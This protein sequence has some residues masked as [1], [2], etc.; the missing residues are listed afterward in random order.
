M[1]HKSEA[2]YDSVFKVI[3]KDFET[4]NKVIMT[5]FEIATRNSFKK[6]MPLADIRGCHFHHVQ[7]TNDL[8][9]YNI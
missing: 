8:I 1:N 9:F 2:A 3:F 6:V 7:V 4:F 5:D